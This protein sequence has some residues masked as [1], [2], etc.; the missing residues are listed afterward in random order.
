MIRALALTLA[1]AF[2]APAVAKEPVPSP[3]AAPRRVDIKVTSKGYE[4]AQLTARPGEKLLL[5]FTATDKMGCCDA[6]IVPAVNASGT[7][8]K[9]KPLEIPVTMPASGKLVFA[10]SMTMCRGEISPAAK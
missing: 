7:V 10:C 1:L 6:I 3:S 4:P 8:T 2:A 5:V 9:E